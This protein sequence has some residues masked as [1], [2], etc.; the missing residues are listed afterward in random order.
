MKLDEILQVR[1]NLNNI[2]GFANSLN[3]CAAQLGTAEK[4]LDNARK[5]IESN[6]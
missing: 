1:K 4:D 5:R 2:A 3:S 6:I